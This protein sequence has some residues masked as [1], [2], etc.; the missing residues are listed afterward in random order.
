MRSRQRT[1]GQGRFL[2]RVEFAHLVPLVEQGVAVEDL[3][4]GVLHT[5]KQHVHAGQVVGGD[6]LFLAKDFADGP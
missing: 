5:V 4:L 6:V 3:E 1:W 2:G